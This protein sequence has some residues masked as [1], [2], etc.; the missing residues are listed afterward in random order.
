MKRNRRHVQLA[1]AGLAVFSSALVIGSCGGD[2]V[3]PYFSNHDLLYLTSE[4]ISR[5]HA[6]G[7]APFVL[8][9]PGG[10]VLGTALG[11][12]GR[13]GIVSRGRGLSE[14]E[15]LRVDV[16]AGR[17]EVLPLGR[18][19][20]GVEVV[21]AAG[22]RVYVSAGGQRVARV[23]VERGTTPAV[24][25][26]FNVESGGLELLPPSPAF[27]EGALG[28]LA[29]REHRGPDHVY[30]L[31]PVT[32]EVMDSVSRSALSL[33]R[34]YRVQSARDPGE[35]LIDGVGGIVRYDLEERTIRAWAARAAVGEY[36]LTPDGS[37][38]L[39]TD[40]G[41]PFGPVSRQ[42]V[43]LY[44]SMSLDSIGTIS[45]REEVPGLG[46]FSGPVTPDGRTAFVVAQYV[47]PG[48]ES[49]RLLVLDLVR[50]TVVEVLRLEGAR[51]GLPFLANCSG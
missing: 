45:A 32:L 34:I 39:L 21:A 38:I 3:A 20:Y 7:L 30:L 1:L 4:G 11:E 9:P 15:L 24:A 23:D 37:T 10:A 6:G 28:V 51:D 50:E 18:T 26:P 13:F 35:I 14:S 43:H 22:D 46:L 2:P 31:H 36:R 12:N 5:I 17:V 47:G 40:S 48:D 33:G 8:F 49:P 29:S 25:H 16:C 19:I 41:L 44:D 42:N 27:P